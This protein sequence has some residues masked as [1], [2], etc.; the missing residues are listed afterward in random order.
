M[1]VEGKGGTTM[2]RNV[3]F[4]LIFSICL[5]MLCSCDTTQR[6]ENLDTSKEVTLTIVGAREENKA[7]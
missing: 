3:I 6:D 4:V 7:L 2:K 5:S 1:Q